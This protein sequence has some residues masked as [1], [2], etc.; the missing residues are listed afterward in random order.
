MNNL[1]SRVRSGSYFD[2]SILM[3]LQ[4]YLSDLPGVTDAGVVMGTPGNKELLE[5]SNLANSETASARADDLV[6]VIRTD[7][8]STADALDEAIDTFF[9]LKKTPAVG[10]KKAAR[11][12]EEAF[13]FNTAADWV[14]ISVNGKYAAREARI[15]LKNNKHVFLFSDNVSLAEEIE[16]KKLAASKNLLVLGPDC[17][18][19]FIKGVGL[20]FANSVRIGS[21]SVV[22][23]A[24]TGLQQ[25]TSRVDQLGGGIQFGIGTGGR[26]LSPKIGA[27]TSLAAIQFLAADAGTKVITL[28][29]KPPDPLI[30]DKVIEAAAAS[31]KPVIVCFIGSQSDHV[32][33]E[34]VQFASSLDEAAE[35]A[36]SASKQSVP[37]A[38][39]LRFTP[40]QK[41]LRGLYSGGTLAYEAQAIL[42]KEIKPIW[43]SSP[44]IKENLLTDAYHA[45][46]NAILDLGDDQFTVG[47]LHP[48]IDQELRLSFLEKESR[49][50]SVALILLDVVLG[51]GSHPD[52]ASELAPAI[53][54]AIRK[55]QNDGGDLSVYVIVCGTQQD[56]QGMNS[57]IEAL[58]AAG[59]IVFTNHQEMLTAVLSQIRKLGLKDIQNNQ[60]SHQASA[61]QLDRPRAVINVGLAQFGVDLEHQGVEVEQVD[62][63]PPAGGNMEL[64]YILDQMNE[65]YEGGQ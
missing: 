54:E 3:G 37:V 28:I 30:A 46:D 40:T 63:S 53:H 32:Y 61:I 6:V 22:A 64:A 49:D 62:W 5:Q 19:A 57:Q 59:A 12:L 31:G 42:G 44:L 36:V 10:T 43:S 13:R 35:M 17:G 58:R 60:S 39:E 56:V 21:I 23:A 41:Y 18:T 50:E 25:F 2:S 7:D 55:R 26:D 34:N 45:V 52:P 20:G 4:K 9:A 29:S 24:G 47:R 51:Y 14:M 48:M 16:L 33:P 38:G 11:D 1:I 27:L 65:P 15:A 8:Q